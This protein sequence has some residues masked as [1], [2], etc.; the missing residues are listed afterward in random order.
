MSMNFNLWFMPKGADGS[1]GPIDS[2]ESRQYQQDIDW[3]LHVEDQLLNTAEVEAQVAALRAGGKRAV[4]Q[5][6][7]KGLAPYCGL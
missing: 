1:I 5:V 6:A 2:P 4:D 3:V 7:E